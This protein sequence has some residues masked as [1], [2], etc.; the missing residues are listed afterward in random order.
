M[1][2][3]EVMKAVKART[4]LAKL[5]TTPSHHLPL[6]DHPR[7]RA[8]T[9]FT[10]SSLRD[11]VHC[12]LRIHGQRWPPRNR[13]LCSL[14]QEVLIQRT[15]WLRSVNHGVEVTIPAN[16]GANTQMAYAPKVAL[17]HPQT[18]H[19]RSGGEGALIHALK[20]GGNLNPSRS[21]NRRLYERRNIQ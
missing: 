11:C 6:I 4:F 12:S 7:I 2:A 20:P 3:V 17:G 1:E 5:A 19:W 16:H 18:E 8:S 10:R 13:Y 14:K 9:P 15:G 21:S